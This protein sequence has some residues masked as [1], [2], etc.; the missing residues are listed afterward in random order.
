MESDIMNFF[1]KIL[2]FLPGVGAVASSRYLSPKSLRPALQETAPTYFFLKRKFNVTLTLEAAAFQQ[3]RTD[4]ETFSGRQ[5][6]R[7]VEAVEFDLLLEATS[8]VVCA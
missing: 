2:A 6:S 7:L 4:L 3:V 8:A 5:L 1:C